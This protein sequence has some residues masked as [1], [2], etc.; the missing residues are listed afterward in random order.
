[1]WRRRPASK[2]VR[3]ATSPVRLGD[4]PKPCRVVRGSF[5]SA[6][7]PRLRF[8]GLT[9]GPLG[10]QY[11]GNTRRFQGKPV[12]REVQGKRRGGL[13]LATRFGSHRGAPI[14]CRAQGFLEERSE[15]VILVEHIQ[16]SLCGATGTR[17][18][19][20]ELGGI[21]R[22]SGSQRRGALDHREREPLRLIRRK[23]K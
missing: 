15:C 10:A 7:A 11:R 5:Q 14:T 6:I 2:V 1:M 19:A 13:T 3:P 4:T 21:V 9:F 8:D 18:P 23:S 20:R 17:H 12:L 16:S 22:R